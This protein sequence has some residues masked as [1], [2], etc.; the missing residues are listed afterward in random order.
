[1]NIY[2][3]QYYNLFYEHPKIFGELV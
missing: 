1:L 3:T 2:K